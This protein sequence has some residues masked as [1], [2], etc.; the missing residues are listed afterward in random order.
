MLLLVVADAVC[1][2]VGFDLDNEA[3]QL[4]ARAVFFGAV[5]PSEGRSSRPSP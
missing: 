3:P 5:A 4:Y 2:G 1:E